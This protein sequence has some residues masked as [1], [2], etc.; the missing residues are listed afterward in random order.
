MDFNELQRKVDQ[1]HWLEFL[2]KNVQEDGK[3]YK[4]ILIT[5][6]QDKFKGTTVCMCNFSKILQRKSKIYRKWKKE[7]ITKEVGC[8]ETIG[9]KG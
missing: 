7:N 3:I 6:K 8:Q 2:E 5:E 4:T 9:T 1:I